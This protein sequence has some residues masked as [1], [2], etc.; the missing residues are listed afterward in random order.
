MIDAHHQRAEETGARIVHTCGFDSIPS[1]LGTWATQQEFI[2]RFGRPAKHV[3]A[4][5][6]ALK[7]GLS[8]GTVASAFE[9]AKASEDRDVRRMLRNPYGL[10]PD[11]TAPRPPAPDVRSM[12]WDARLRMFTIPFVMGDTNARV[13]RR[14]HALAGFPWG[15]DF[16]YREMMTTPGN[17]RGLALATGMMGGLAGLALVLKRPRLREL[18]EQRAP[19]PGQGPNE[20]TRNHGYW[21]VQFVAEGNGDSL[22]YGASDPAGDPGYGSTSKMLAESALCLAFDPLTSPGGVQTPAVAMA[23]PLLERLRS[24][25]LQFA[26]RN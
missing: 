9:I 8:G 26:P 18:V 4:Y 12:G 13:V 2:R 6:G 3:T 7:G 17:A 10:D 16:V 21:K 19:K 23:A 15:E 25:G 14:G 20:H 1:D 11:P 22:L 5:Y 24:A